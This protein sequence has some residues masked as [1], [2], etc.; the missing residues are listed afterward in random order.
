MEEDHDDRPPE[1]K[2]PEAIHAF[3]GSVMVLYPKALSSVSEGE[4]CSPTSS[5]VFRLL[6]SKT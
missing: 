2:A 5:Q 4:Y 1:E 3:W 6:Y